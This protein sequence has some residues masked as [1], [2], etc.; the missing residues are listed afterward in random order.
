MNVIIMVLSFVTLIVFAVRESN[1]IG[2]STRTIT[3]HIH[4]GNM[5]YPSY[6]VGM[7][8]DMFD[9]VFSIVRLMTKPTLDAD[10]VKDYYRSDKMCD[11]SVCSTSTDSTEKCMCTKYAKGDMYKDSEYENC[12]DNMQGI[13]DVTHK[14]ATGSD[15]MHF[16]NN[17]LG[18]RCKAS[19]LNDVSITPN[20]AWGMLCTQAPHVLGMVLTIIFFLWSVENLCHLYV[21]DKHD[22]KDFVGKT[23]LKHAKDYMDWA[24][25][26]EHTKKYE[27]IAFLT[28][29]M[30]WMVI[31][32]AIERGS[33]P[34]QLKMPEDEAWK[35]KQ[36]VF[37]G[38]QV[39]VNDQKMQHHYA[40][41]VP[42]GSWTYGF[43]IVLLWGVNLMLSYLFEFFRRSHGEHGHAGPVYGPVDER[44]GPVD[45]RYETDER[46]YTHNP[47]PFEPND[48]THNSHLTRAKST[49]A[50]WNLSAFGMPMDKPVSYS[51][52]LREDHAHHPDST[53]GGYGTDWTWSTSSVHEQTQLF[54]TAVLL[55]AVLLNLTMHNRYVADVNVWSVVFLVVAYGLLD[56]AVRRVSELVVTVET[57]YK[58]DYKSKFVFILGYLLKLTLAL[59]GLIYI[60]YETYQSPLVNAYWVKEERSGSPGFAMKDDR[61]DAQKHSEN[62]LLYSTIALWVAI[63]FVDTFKDWSIFVSEQ[64]AKH[65]KLMLST[66]SNEESRVYQLVIQMLLF[67]YFAFSLYA[68]YFSAL[69]SNWKQH[70]ELHLSKLTMYEWHRNNWLY[71]VSQ[72]TPM[73]MYRG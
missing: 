39:V 17:D 55:T 60:Y 71:G 69:L 34:D 25:K 36:A 12:Q 48:T 31:F 23:H 18:L 30:V 47:K 8:T 27:A 43:V 58:I 22:D 14:H 41:A 61:I 13:N 50:Q 67:A 49:H 2:L 72:Q 70:P 29:L 51:L 35:N 10:G 20:H 6:Q 73:A 11:V 59:L 56:A 9:G 68:L 15:L 21:E 53:A 33:W 63:V 64:P 1:G 4:K 46:D 16:T 44:Y 45:E 7:S 65:T 54:K 40:R 24:L 52:L 37:T 26:K 42:W 66:A 32:L 57:M 5:P 62:W 3:T 28:L 19:M 38:N